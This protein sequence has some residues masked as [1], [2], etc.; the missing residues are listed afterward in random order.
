MMTLIIAWILYGYI[1]I[2]MDKWK[3]MLNHTSEH[4]W[5]SIFTPFAYPR[6]GKLKL[7]KIELKP[8]DKP[9]LALRSVPFNFLFYKGLW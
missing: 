3:G 5:T 2:I 6:Q 1:I 7:L 4:D 9:S 8:G